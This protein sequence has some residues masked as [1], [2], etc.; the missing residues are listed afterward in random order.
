MGQ[1]IGLLVSMGAE[2]QSR[3]EAVPARGSGTA[4]A[5]RGPAAAAGAGGNGD[6][7]DDD[8]DAFEEAAPEQ[9]GEDRATSEGDASAADVV[10][11]AQGQHSGAAADAD[12]S[13][14]AGP[15]EGSDHLSGEGSS[16]PA[17]SACS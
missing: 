12:L 14:S 8:F 13:V 5:G 1:V 15:E 16:R 3:Q 10:A 4:P 17:G 7:D 11:E 9:P 2:L 6:E